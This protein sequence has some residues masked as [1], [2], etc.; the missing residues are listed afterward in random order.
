MLSAHESGS[1]LRVWVVPGANRPAIAGV[2]GEALKVRVASP[3]ERSRA[4]DD[5]IRLIADHFECRVTVIAGH[6]SRSKLLLL[7]GLPVEAAA[8][9]LPA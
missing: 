2:H 5:L 8:S 3:A 7:H 9:F 4:N 1:V 6:R